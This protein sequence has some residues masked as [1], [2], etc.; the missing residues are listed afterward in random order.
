MVSEYVLVRVSS[1]SVEGKGDSLEPA[2]P[3]AESLCTFL[4]HPNNYRVISRPCPWRTLPDL[5]RS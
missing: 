4:Q 2:A 5:A 3:C 1:L